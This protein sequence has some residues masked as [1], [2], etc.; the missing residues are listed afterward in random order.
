MCVRWLTLTVH[1]VRRYVDFCDRERA[2]GPVRRQK[3]A[4][5]VCVGRVWASYLRWSRDFKNYTMQ[6]ALYGGLS[7]MHGFRVETAQICP[8]LCVRA[9]WEGSKYTVLIPTT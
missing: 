4:R 5:V 6:R 9:C 8:Y 2:S 7:C 3:W 1:V